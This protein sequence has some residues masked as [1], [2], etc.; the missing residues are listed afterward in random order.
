MKTTPKNHHSWSVKEILPIGVQHLIF[1][2]TVGS[3]SGY[4]LQERISW[5]NPEWVFESNFTPAGT[6]GFRYW[7][8]ASAL[9]L[10]VWEVP[11]YS[12]EQYHIPLSQWN[13][14]VQ[15]KLATHSET[16]DQTIHRLFQ[17]VCEGMRTRVDSIND[18]LAFLREMKPGQCMDYD[19]YDTYSTPNRDHRVFDDFAALR[20]TYKEMLASNGAAGVA[21]AIKPQ[22][23][24][25]FP[26]LEMSTAD[27]VAHM[28]E[29]SIDQRST[30]LI[31]Y[32]PG[33]KIDL[34][35]AKRRL[36]ADLMSNNPL[37]EVEY[38]WGEIK[39]PSAHAKACPSWDPWSPDLT[40][41]N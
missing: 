10:P 40:Q 4:G 2:S 9:N 3:H 39:G 12:D 31:E 7:R 33:K 28:T 11:N 29:S 15:A 38:R 35:E 22:L 20:R 23:E 36:F 41:G 34:A 14:V 16:D 21:P 25:I 30:C 26:Y 6:A 8:P 24:K 27:E 19:T 18:G 32:S 13:Q 17:T 5:P 1:N 37:D